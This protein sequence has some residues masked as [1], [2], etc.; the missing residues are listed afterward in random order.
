[1]F[2]FQEVTWS[3]AVCAQ[4]CALRLNVLVFLTFDPCFSSAGTSL[5]GAVLV[6]RWFLSHPILPD[7]WPLPERQEELS[8]FPCCS[9][10]V[11]AWVLTLRSHDSLSLSK[12]LDGAAGGSI[13]LA[14]GSLGPGT[15]LFLAQL[16]PGPRFSHL[17]KEGGEGQW[18]MRLRNQRR[19]PLPPGLGGAARK[20][21]PCPMSPGFPALRSL[22]SRSKRELSICFMSAAVRLIVPFFH[23]GSFLWLFVCTTSSCLRA[24]PPPL[25]S[26]PPGDL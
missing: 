7:I 22:G 8:L 14:P 23:P 1:M 25:A 4:G 11:G 24:T 17:S 13:P 18:R 3:L 12:R 5:L 26:S 21:G 6:A 10:A 9:A 20:Q 16:M 19:P 2:A 15:S